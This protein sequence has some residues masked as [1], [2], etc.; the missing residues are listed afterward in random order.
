MRPGFFAPFPEPFRRL[1]PHRK[2]GN[3]E[4]LSRPAC[5]RL[6]RRP[7]P[8]PPG[9][10]SHRASVSFFIGKKKTEI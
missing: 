6:R 10:L 7:F 3:A 2:A 1:F 5:F 4:V 8:A 9:I